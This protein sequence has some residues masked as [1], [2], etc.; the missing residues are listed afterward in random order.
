M[1]IIITKEAERPENYN[2]IYVN[3]YYIFVHAV[4]GVL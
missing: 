4:Y 2:G 3:D 1:H